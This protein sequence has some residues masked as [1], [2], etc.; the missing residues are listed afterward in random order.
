[1]KTAN[2]LLDLMQEDRQDLIRFLSARL[3]NPDSAADV[4][5]SLFEKLLSKNTAPEIQSPRAYLYRAAANEATS[6]QRSKAVRESYE[7]AAFFQRAPVNTQDPEKLTLDKDALTCLQVALKELPLL[8]QRMF[9]AFRLGGDTQAVIAKRYGV[10][11]STVEKRIA[12]A[13]KH[14]H[15]RLQQ[16]GF[17]EFLPQPR[18]KCN[19]KIKE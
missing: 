1:M 18:L 4:Y 3:G 14:C 6:Y 5:Q 10:S 13:A 11:L 9:I 15:S 19:S 7:E 17:T 2:A 16:K 8:T 12:K